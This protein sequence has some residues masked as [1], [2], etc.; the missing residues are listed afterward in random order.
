[1]SKKYELKISKKVIK[2]MKKLPRDAQKQIMNRIKQLRT[3]PH[4][5]TEKIKGYTKYSKLRAGNYRVI[6][7]ILEKD[8][9]ILIVHVGHRSKVYEEIERFL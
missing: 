3:D 4:R 9:E 2:E 8:K 1:M 6:M 7:Q 5:I